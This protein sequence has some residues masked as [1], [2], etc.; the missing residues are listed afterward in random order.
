MR[1]VIRGAMTLVAGLLAAAGVWAGDS[2]APDSPEM[3]AGSVPLPKPQYEAPGIRVPAFRGD[4]AVRSSVSTELAAQFIEDGARAWTRSRGC[5]SCHTTGTYA[6]TRPVLSPL[7]GPP[8]PEVRALMVSRLRRKQGMARPELLRGTESG[9]AVYIAAGLAEWDRCVEGKAS[10]ETAEA[11]DLLF[12]LQLESGSW[13]NPGCWPPYESD[14]YHLATQAALAVAAAPG[15]LS[16]ATVERR[17]RVE[18]LKTY[19]RSTIPPHDYARTLLLWA[20][21]RMPDLIDPA[22]RERLVSMILG[23]QQADGGWSIRTFAAPEAWGDGS[24]AKKLRE[25]PEFVHP[26]SDGHQTGLAIVVLRE[27]GVPASDPRIQ[28]GVAWLKANQRE[29]GRWWTRSL[30]T[31]KFHYVTYSGT[32]FPL[33]A[34]ASCSEVPPLLHPGAPVA[35]ATARGD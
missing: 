9:E 19:L 2:A 18:R 6:V 16:H 29:S 31:D 21:L 23:H 32:L 17:E 12:D 25:E 4:E 10:A 22:G 33:L 20:S 27:A 5:I 8:Q 7:L 14:S 15:W 1:A 35:Q 13:A 3:R 28:R 24:R 26:P 30:N 11:L 34:L